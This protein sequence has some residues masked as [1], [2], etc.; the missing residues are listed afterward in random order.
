MRGPAYRPHHVTS[1]FKESLTDAVTFEQR[2]EGS[3]RTIQVTSGGKAS[4]TD[5]Q[6]QK[7]G[8]GNT[9]GQHGGSNL[10]EENDKMRSESQQGP[11]FAMI[12]GDYLICT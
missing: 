11:I 3:V 2:F 5:V 12:F 9:L 10:G 8:G 4:Q 7:P 1:L 6:M